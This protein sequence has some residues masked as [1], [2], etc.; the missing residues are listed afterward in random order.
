MT[1]KN[2]EIPSW[3]LLRVITSGEF[4]LLDWESR[5][6]CWSDSREASSL[7]EEREGVVGW[8]NVCY[9]LLW[10]ALFDVIIDDDD[11]DDDSVWHREQSMMISVV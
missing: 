10:T 6:N 5:W 8:G 9:G 7:S 3:F 1:K 2:A 11:G 4:F